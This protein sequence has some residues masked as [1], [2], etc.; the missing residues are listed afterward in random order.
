MVTSTL[1]I[2]THQDFS[3]VQFPRPQKASALKMK[4][5][6][7]PF[8]IFKLGKVSL[9]I[10]GSL[11]TSLEILSLKVFLKTLLADENNTTDF[12]RTDRADLQRRSSQSGLVKTFSAFIVGR[13]CFSSPV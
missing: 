5:S 2:R 9:F 11:S 6:E 13:F 1:Q 7:I 12:R 8:Y 10:S 3:E 4:S